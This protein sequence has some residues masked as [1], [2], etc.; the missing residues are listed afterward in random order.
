MA[1][2]EAH[3]EWPQPLWFTMYYPVITSG[4]TYLYTSGRILGV[5]QSLEERYPPG[6]SAMPREVRMSIKISPGVLQN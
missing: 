6:M 2:I 4:G 5:M 1:L 3:R